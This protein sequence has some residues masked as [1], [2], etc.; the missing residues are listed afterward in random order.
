MTTQDLLDYYKGLLII[1]YASLPNA[2]GTVEAYVAQ[3]IQDQIVQKVQDAFDINTAIGVQL[4]IL[5]TYRGQNRQVFGLVPANYMALPE[6]NDPNAST[7]FGLAEYN[8]PDPTWNFMQYNDLNGLAYTLTDSQMRRI[9]LFEAMIDSCPMGYGELDAIL[10]AF[11][12]ANVNLVDNL[13]MSMTYNHLVTD[14]DLDSLFDIAVLSD[15]LP[16][17]AG[18]SFNVV[19][20]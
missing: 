3:L 1:Q 6:Y 9:I 14:P 2:L 20:V 18:V 12:G 11:F 13:N 10:Y 17:P 16:H 7:Y 15:A 4:N 19:E 5:G 8:D